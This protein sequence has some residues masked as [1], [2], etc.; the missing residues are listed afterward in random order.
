MNRV[1]TISRETQ[2]RLFIQFIVANLCDLC[3]KK[4][5][6]LSIF[7]IEFSSYMTVPPR[8]C[9]PLL[10]CSSVPFF[11]YI[12]HLLLESQ[13]VCT[14]QHFTFSCIFLMGKVP[15]QYEQLKRRESSKESTWRIHALYLDNIS[16]N[17]DTTL[18]DTIEILL[19]YLSLL[20]IIDI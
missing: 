16:Y 3:I 15:I 18:I 20:P 7:H 1:I 12:K 13:Q 17:S 14:Y 19:T 6:K 5:Y 9:L 2:E 4:N 10:I 8:P 11:L